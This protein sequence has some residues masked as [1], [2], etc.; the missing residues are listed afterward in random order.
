MLETPTT[1][2]SREDWPLIEEAGHRLIHEEVAAAVA[3]ALAH[4]SQS[5]L[6]D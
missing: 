1:H 3:T 5:L 6:K 2:A 4:L